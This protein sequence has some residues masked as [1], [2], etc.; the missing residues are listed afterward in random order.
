MERMEIETDLH[1]TPFNGKDYDL[2]EWEDKNYGTVKFEQ[3][4][5]ITRE[6]GGIKQSYAILHPINMFEEYD[7]VGIVFAL[8]RDSVGRIYLKPEE[9]AAI[10]IEIF[11]EFYRTIEK[12]KESMK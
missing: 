2:V 3:V 6:R 12:N 5:I 1:Y 4:A 9:D 8:K 11:N 7:E 10:V